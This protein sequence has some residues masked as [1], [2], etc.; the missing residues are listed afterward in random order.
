VVIAMLGISSLAASG[1][2]PSLDAQPTVNIVDNTEHIQLSKITNAKGQPTSCVIL[3]EREGYAGYF[4]M[5][6]DFS[7]EAT[8]P[9]E[10]T[11]ASEDTHGD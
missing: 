9:S 3:V 8:F 11:P 2:G 6:C 1:C 7:G 10:G 5:D 4:G